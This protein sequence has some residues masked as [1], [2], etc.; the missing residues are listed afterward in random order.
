MLSAGLCFKHVLS[1]GGT[2]VKETA[3]VLGLRGVE[4][5]AKVTQLLKHWNWDVPLRG[6]SSSHTTLQK[7]SP[8]APV[9]PPFR[10]PHV[11][12]SC[13]WRPSDKSEAAE[14]VGQA[15][16]LSAALL[17]LVGVLLASGFANAKKTPGFPSF[18]LVSRA[19][20]AHLILKM[21]AECMLP[22]GRLS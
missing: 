15:D 1:A 2:M 18:V 17:V 13:P 3:S 6:V 7:C 5:L 4:S 14:W 16:D 21:P 11:D 19:V 8:W 20:T 9:L 10:L 22:R 12:T